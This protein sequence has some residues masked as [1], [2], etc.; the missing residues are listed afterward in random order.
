MEDLDST[1][2][3]TYIDLQKNTLRTSSTGSNLSTMAA[4]AHTAM[5]RATNEAVKVAHILK[6]KTTMKNVTSPSSSPITSPTLRAAK[7]EPI[8]VGEA[9]QR[10]QPGSDVPWMN[11]RT[12]G[13][14][15]V[16]TSNNS[17]TMTD[18]LA[19]S[20]SRSDNDVMAD[21]IAS[22]PKLKKLDEWLTQLRKEE[23]TKDTTKVSYAGANVAVIIV[24]VDFISAFLFYCL[25][26]NHSL[27][28]NQNSIY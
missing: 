26:Y 9:L 11:L 5:K 12:A 28:T 23:Q 15:T 19:A 27:P 21:Q 16:H 4:T 3:R 20:L 10:L 25:L 13:I 1:A 7:N 8:D 2:V 22:D 17:E 14:A 18:S 6:E 24:R